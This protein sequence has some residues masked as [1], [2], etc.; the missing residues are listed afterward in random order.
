MIR[1]AAIW[2]SVLLAAGPL[3]EQRSVPPKKDSRGLLSVSVDS[4]ELAA[5]TGG[6]FYFWAPGEFAASQLQI[7]V[8]SDEVLLAYGK[9]AGKR[10]FEVP[11]ESS[12][13][14][15]TLF[16]GVQRKDLVTIV[17][18][19]GT[20]GAHGRAGI[21]IQT[22]QHMTIA[23]VDAPTPGLWRIELD[24]EGLFAV[25]AHVRLAANGAQLIGARFVEQ[26]GRPGHEGL[27]PVEKAPAPGVEALCRVHIGGNVRELQLVFFRRDGS[28]ISS[29]PM[30]ATSDGESVAPCKVPREPYRFGLTAK[31]GDGHALQRIDRPLLEP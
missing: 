22:F 31:D 23:T 21:A 11:V 28:P 20:V 16:V 13:R 6:D 29:V 9:A 7:P 3:Q 18:P 25:T 15:L 10:T 17:R 19:D 12:V 5:Q 8:E 14:S 27:F 24:G 1:F 26:R 2:V 4:Y 30:P